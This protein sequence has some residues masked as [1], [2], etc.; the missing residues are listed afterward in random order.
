MRLVIAIAI[1]AL[2]VVAHPSRVLG[3]DGTTELAEVTRR[4]NGIETAISQTGASGSTVTVGVS[5]L[6]GCTFVPSLAPSEVAV[7]LTGHAIFPAEPIHLDTQRYT[8]I[9]CSETDDRPLF[10]EFWPEGSPPPPSVTRFLARE[11]LARTEVA[12]PRPKGAPD[13][14]D[15]DYLVNLAN[16]WWLDDW[17]AATGTASLPAPNPVSVTAVLTPTTSTWMVEGHD[18]IVCQQGKPW[19]PSLDDDD[20]DR[21]GITF[22]HHGEQLEQT[23]TVSYEVSFTCA[24]AALCGQIPAFEP[25][26]V[27]T[28]TTVDIIQIRGLLVS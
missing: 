26:A 9:I 16:W 15:V 19:N 8:M 18:P 21:C 23:V 28:S 2:A 4:S 11:A 6:E 3:A 12:Y 17:N 27:T 10:Y 25:I 13:G 24:P 1:L 5:R 20:P 14:V 7:E 22:I